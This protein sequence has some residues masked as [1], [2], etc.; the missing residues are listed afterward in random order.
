MADVLSDNSPCEDNDRAAV[1]SI[2]NM[3]AKFSVS[4]E[5]LTISMSSPDRD[6]FANV[7]LSITETAELKKVL[8]REL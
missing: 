5:A 6:P 4:G 1:I 8:M 3:P 7:H 2:A